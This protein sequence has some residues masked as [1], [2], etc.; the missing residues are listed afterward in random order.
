M[1]LALPQHHPDHC[2]PEAHRSARAPRVGRW[3]AVR[4]RSARPRPPWL[5]SL[6]VLTGIGLAGCSKHQPAEVE[7]EIR[8][9]GFD[10][11]TRS[12]VVVLQD[13]DR[14][15]ALPIWI[16]PAEAQSI[17]MQIEG[18]NPPRPMTHDLVKTILDGAGVEFDRVVIQELR[19]STYYAHIFLRSG[20]HDLEIDSRPSDAIALAVRFKRPIFVATGLMRSDSSIDLMHDA[21][22]ASSVK[23]SGVTV[24]NLTDE[25]SG[26][27][28]L[29]PGQ[30]VLVADIESEGA[31]GLQRG[32]VVLEIDGTTVTGV[33]DFERKVRALANGASARLSVQRGDARIDVQWIGSTG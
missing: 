32:D 5:A 24:Q 21:P 26:Y 28:S 22:T 4:L 1:N 17:A 2:E 6:V 9:V 31:G 14:R 27:F 30:G 8:S 20:R 19:G 7:V 10:N 11:S 3:T 25:L 15:V 29:P 12:P 13:H 23:M 16:G 33:G 18:I